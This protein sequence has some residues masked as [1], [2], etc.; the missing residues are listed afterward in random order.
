MTDRKLPHNNND[1]IDYFAADVVSYSDYYPF[2]QLLPGRHGSEAEYRYGFQ[3]QEKDDEIKGEGNSVNYTYRM[4]DPRVGRFFAIDPLADEYP[5]NSPYAFSENRL[6]DGVE[7]EGLEW[8]GKVSQEILA[9]EKLIE[10]LPENQKEQAREDLLKGM[11][12]GSIGAAVIIGAVI[13]LAATGGT[14][15]SIAIVEQLATQNARDAAEIVNA[16][17]IDPKLDE[18]MIVIPLNPSPTKMG[19]KPKLKVENKKTKNPHGT[20]KNSRQIEN[21]PKTGKPVVDEEAVGRAHSQIATK[22]SSNKK[23]G[24]Y[25]TARTIDSKGNVRKQI[26]YTDHGR[27]ANHKNPHT[28]NYHKD[29]QGQYKRQ[30]KEFYD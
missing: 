14:F 8:G 23:V 28:H 3:G 11:Q 30:K 17:S 15:T 4:H 22:T 10:N 27:A 2:G 5:H 18:D 20:Y 13:D 25:A 16:G 7:L 29:A 6:I 1:T 21:N 26:D 12:K 19:T 24:D 9:N